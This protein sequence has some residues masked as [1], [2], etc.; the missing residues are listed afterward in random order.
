MYPHCRV[1][2]LHLLMY[3]GNHPAIV[4]ILSYLGQHTLLRIAIMQMCECS[5]STCFAAL[6]SL[7]S[8]FRDM[9]LC[10]SG[11]KSCCIT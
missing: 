6:S 3:V 11:S 10:A 9:N 5:A 1:L 8:E 7:Y 4:I 2:A